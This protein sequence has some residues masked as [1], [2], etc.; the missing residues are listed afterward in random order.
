MFAYQI[1]MWEANRFEPG[2]ESTETLPEDGEGVVA[3]VRVPQVRD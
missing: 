1:S 3:S 2:A